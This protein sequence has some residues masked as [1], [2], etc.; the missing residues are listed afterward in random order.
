MAIP[1]DLYDSLPTDPE[2]AFL[3]LEQVFREEC[4]NNIR[5]LRDDENPSIH[6]VD[7]IAQVIGAIAEL[8]LEANF[9]TDVPLIEDVSPNTYLNFSKDVKNYCT[10]LQ[11]RYGRRVQ[12]FSVRFDTAAKA[13]IHNYIT[14]IRE[15]VQKLEV[16][17]PKKEAL[18]KRLTRFAEEV[19]SDRTRLEAFGEVV[20]S[21]SSIAGQAAEKLEPIRRWVDSIGN[22][23]NGAREVEQ[24]T[25]Q[26]PPVKLP[27]R[28]EVQKQSPSFARDLDDEVPF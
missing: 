13:T 17:V 9:S 6:H 25:K 8:G 23:I 22:L 11:I 1:E 4:E 12:G 5:R 16:D 27:K 3:I 28:I 15:V 2:Q 26:L 18:L 10:R 20:L 24:A 7:Y 19:D 14:K 21:V